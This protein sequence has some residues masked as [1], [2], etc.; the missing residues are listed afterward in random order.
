[1]SAILAGAILKLS[2]L[3]ISFSCLAHNHVL[4]PLWRLTRYSVVGDSPISDVVLANDQ[5]R[6]DEEHEKEE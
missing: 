1:M 6:R 3:I 4:K 5:D 2:N